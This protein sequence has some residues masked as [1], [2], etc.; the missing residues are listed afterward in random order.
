MAAF[1]FVRYTQCLVP[2]I[3]SACCIHNVSHTKSKLYC[4]QN[5][6][7]VLEKKTE[8]K[9]PGLNVDLYRADTL[10]IALKTQAQSKMW[11][12]FGRQVSSFLDFKVSVYSRPLVGR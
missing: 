10:Q 4:M 6:V 1:N 5:D 7:E 12:Y 2:G 3:A 11:S 8:K 9:Y